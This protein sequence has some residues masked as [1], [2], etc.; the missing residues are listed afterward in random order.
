[1]ISQ[2]VASALDLFWQRV[3]DA[4][5]K[6]HTEYDSEWPSVCEV[7]QHWIDSYG[8]AQ[9]EW[10]PTQRSTPSA[11]FTK[12]EEALGFEL[13]PD[14]KTYYSRY[15]GANVQAH[16]PDGDL[17]LLFLWNEADLDL[18]IENLIGHVVACRNNKTP[19]AVFFAVAEPDTDYFLTVNNETGQVQL[20][21]PGKKPLQVVAHSLAEF[22]NALEPGWRGG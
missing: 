21:E 16:A 19:F 7:G 13:H 11:D 6:L 17:T 18:L 3:A 10:Q 14:I 5:D 2:A 12:F 8:N 15:W 4:T 9:I 22:L 20:E 1:M